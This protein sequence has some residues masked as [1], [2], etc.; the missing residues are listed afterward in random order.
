[1]TKKILAA[2]ALLM[3]GAHG[4]A[5]QTVEWRNGKAVVTAVSP[6]CTANDRNLGDTF[7]ARYRHPNLGSN[8]NQARLSIF[9]HRQAHIFIKNGDLNNTFQAIDTAG[10]IG[11][12]LVT[13][14]SGPPAGPYRPQIR[15]VR[16]TANITAATRTIYMTLKI[17]SFFVAQDVT[18]CHL[19][20]EVT[21]LK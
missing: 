11:G 18:N 16:R 13:H 6:A 2:A 5:A 14:N 7:E 3:L 4:A 1:M 15:M 19:D 10:F 20:L 17:R 8:G 9:T 21:L 12:G